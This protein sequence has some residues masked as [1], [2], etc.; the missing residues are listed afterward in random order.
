MRPHYRAAAC[1]PPRPCYWW[2]VETLPGLSSPQREHPYWCCPCSLFAS[3]SFCQ[4]VVPHSEKAQES[5]RQEAAY[6]PVAFQAACRRQCRQMESLCRHGTASAESLPARH[7]RA[8][9]PKKIRHCRQFHL[10]AFCRL[11]ARI[12]ACL[13]LISRFSTFSSLYGVRV[14]THTSSMGTPASPYNG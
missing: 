11:P 8:R 7:G 5:R 9:I 10:T 4:F 12:L 14:V 1:C 3:P 6:G 13:T 2:S